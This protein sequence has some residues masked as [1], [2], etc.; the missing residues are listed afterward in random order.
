MAS[1]GV[2]SHCLTKRKRPREGAKE[3]ALILRR[4]DAHAKIERDLTA[5]WPPEVREHCRLGGYR[6][7][8]VVLLVDSPA[9]ATRLR[10]ALPE[11][12]ENNEFLQR[13]KK[14]RIKVRST[15]ETP[16]EPS[17]RKPNRLS[18]KAA[19][20]LLACSE[21]IDDDALADS[22]RRLAKQATRER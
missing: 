11:L 12:I 7:G 22:L 14:I 8:H 3:L 16:P 13:A 19:D 2:L 15:H 18:T 5:D 1:P 4:A 17:P 21:A 6:D 9:W 20:V 10:Y